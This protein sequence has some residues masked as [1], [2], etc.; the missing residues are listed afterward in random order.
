[1]SEIPGIKELLPKIAAI[2][3]I[4]DSIASLSSI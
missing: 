2:P 4:E 1:M 3:H